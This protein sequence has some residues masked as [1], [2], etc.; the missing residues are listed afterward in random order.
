MVHTGRVEAFTVV[1]NSH[2][3]IYDFVAAVAVNVDYTKV[4]VALAG[5]CLIAGS[6]GVEYPFNCE[7]FTIPIVSCQNAA[8]VVATCHNGRWTY[9]VEISHSGKEAV[10]AVCISVAPSFDIAAWR[11]IFYRCHFSTCLAVENRY[12]FRARDNASVEIAPVCAAVAENFA[13]TVGG[14]V[15][16]LAD[17]FGFAVAIEIGNEELGIVCTRADVFAKVDTPFE[18]AVEFV[19]IKVC[20]ACE[21]VVG[22]IV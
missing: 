21:T 9:T 3:A 20:R 16:S 8:G 6:V 15:G 4:V 10:G 14:A 22:V 18:C 1:V 13:L 12:V 11:N 7:V 5:V 17:E 19:A 2:L